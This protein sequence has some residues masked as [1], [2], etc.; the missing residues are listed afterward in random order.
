LSSRLSNLVRIEQTR[1]GIA[2]LRA[3][4]DQWISH[5]QKKDHLGQYHTQL[6]LLGGVLANALERLAAEAAGISGERAAGG[7][8]AE[9]RRCERRT[10]WLRR[11]WEYF[12]RKFDQRDD[13]ALGPVLAAADEV[14]W[15]CWAGIFRQADLP[16]R[17]RWPTSSRCTRRR[18]CRGPI[19]RRICGRTW[20]R[21]F[22]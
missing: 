11:V 18:R 15:S 7:V 21:T 12:R 19:R 5:R 10:V 20:M 8:Y 9:C 17:R 6:K 2:G 14:V 13:A 1:R 4:T 22:C 3:E 16:V